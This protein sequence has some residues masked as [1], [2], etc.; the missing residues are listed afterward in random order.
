MEEKDV[1]KKWVIM[2]MKMVTT[3]TKTMTKK[4][5]ITMMMTS[6]LWHDRRGY[7]GEYGGGIQLPLKMLPDS[8]V[9]KAFGHRKILSN[10]TMDRQ[11]PYMETTR[12]TNCT[13]MTI[14][15]SNI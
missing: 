12:M 15:D 9:R 10:I 6:F 13:G 11:L 7:M 1:L 8:S 5:T 4:M 2:I 14:P 3:M